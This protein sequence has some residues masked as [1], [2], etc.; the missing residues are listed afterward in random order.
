[1]TVSFSVVKILRILSGYSKTVAEDLI[2][3]FSLETV[4]KLYISLNHNDFKGKLLANELEM[5][6]KN[7]FEQFALD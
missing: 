6:Y 4:I 7:S 5:D 1:M 2:K 3:K